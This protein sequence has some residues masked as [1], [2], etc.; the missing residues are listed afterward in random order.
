MKNQLDIILEKL[1]ALK[2]QSREQKLQDVDKWLIR[3]TKNNTLTVG[4]TL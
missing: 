4:G 1:E 3:N 2:P